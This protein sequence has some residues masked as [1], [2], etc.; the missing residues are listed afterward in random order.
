MNG[1]GSRRALRI[2]ARHQ[3]QK[4]KKK[5]RKQRR[6]SNPAGRARVRTATA[7]IIKATRRGE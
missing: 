3:T 2:E 5:E 4:K 7:Q 1:G 6:S